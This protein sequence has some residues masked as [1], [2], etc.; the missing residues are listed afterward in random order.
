M[1]AMLMQLIN[2]S[3]NPLK[4]NKLQL[5]RIC[6]WKNKI[7]SKLEKRKKHERKS[8]EKVSVNLKLNKNKYL[9]WI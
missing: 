2:N 1:H 8:W 9:F 7:N 3:V 5:K 4:L 6:T